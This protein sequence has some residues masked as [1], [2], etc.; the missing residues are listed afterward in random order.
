MTRPGMIADVDG[1]INLVELDDGGYA[2]VRVG[3][4]KGF[5]MRLKI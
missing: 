2:G 4:R 1:S 5:E 3:W